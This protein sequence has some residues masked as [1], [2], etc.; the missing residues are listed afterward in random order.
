LYDFVVQVDFAV[1]LG[2]DD[3]TLEIPWEDVQGACRYLDLKRYPELLDKLPEAAACPELRDFL[4]SV[5]SSACVV[6]TVKCDVWSTTEIN[7]EEDIFEAS[8]KFGSYVDFLFADSSFRESFDAHEKLAR[9]LTNLLKKAPE[10]PASAEF[11]IRRCYSRSQSVTVSDAF[12]ITCY[13]FGYA[14]TKE[15]ARKQWGIAL[16]LVE[17]AIR[18]VSTMRKS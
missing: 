12:Y 17:N 9:E 3:P 8:W 15:H 6:E 11:L 2:R 1:E 18:Q 7:P 4:V 14:D 13:V 10:I 16:K 5:N